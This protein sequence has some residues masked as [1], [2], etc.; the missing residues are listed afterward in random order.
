MAG[1]DRVGPASVEDKRQALRA[2]LRAAQGEVRLGKD[3][4]H[5]FRTRDRAPALRLDARAFSRVL[6]VDASAGIVDVEG[7]ATFESLA[8][9]AFAHG[10]LPAVVP[11]L[12]S[13]TIG[14]ACAGLGIESSSFRYGLVHETVTE[15]E[16]LLADGDIVICTPNNAHSDLFFGFANSFGTLGYALRIKAKTVP[17]KPYVELTHVRHEEPTRYFQELEAACAGPDWDFVDGVIFGP[18]DHYLTLGRFVDH[19]PLTSD[20]T[21]MN[22]YYRSIRVAAAGLSQD[23]RLHLA[24]G[25]RLVLVLARASCAEPGRAPPAR[26][27]T[28][29]LDV[30]QEGDRLGAWMPRAPTLA[31]A[32]FGSPRGDHSGRGRAGPQRRQVP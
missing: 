1:G 26:A 25:Y 17:A 32:V 29:Q 23:A 7:M 15:L 21:Y 20:Y 6:K 16:V 31:P 18:D 19:A 24:L 11:Q 30:L 4:S 14:G 27:Q 9:A 5:L 28:A 22:I 13:I 12:K 3:V 2:Q 10:V 8:A